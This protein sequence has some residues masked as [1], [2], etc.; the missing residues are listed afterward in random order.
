MTIVGWLWVGAQRPRRARAVARWSGSRGP[1]VSIGDVA[2]VRGRRSRASLI[3][4]VILARSSAARSPGASSPAGGPQQAI[5]EAMTEPAAE[6]SDAPVLKEKMEDALAT[7]QAHRR[8]PAPSALYDLPW[9]LIIGPPGAGK[10]TAL[11]NS[12]P[13]VSARRATARQGGPGRRRHALLRLVVHRR[14]GADRHRRPLHDAG[15]RRQGRPQ[16]LARLPRHAAAGTGRASRSTA[17]SSR[18]ASPTS[19]IFRPTEVTA[20]ADAIRKRLDELHEELKVDF[21]GLRDVHQDG[22]R[23]RL[24]PVFR[25]SRRGQAAGGLGR[26]LP[27]READKKANNV[28]KVPGG[29]RPPHPA[30]LRADAGAAAGR[31]GPALARDPVRLPGAA[32]ARSASRSPI[33]STASSSRRATRRRRRCA[34]SISPRARRRARRSTR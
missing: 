34:A 32:R 20:H 24:H 21:P 8:S 31:A 22:P 28:G 12:G 15:F 27:G 33:S 1:L 13:E 26:D 10:T 4:L 25:R 5:D 3:I 16:E 29:D 18:S 7:L 30:R 19:S 2:A 14:G 11:V 17:S 23:R 6:E 9:Y